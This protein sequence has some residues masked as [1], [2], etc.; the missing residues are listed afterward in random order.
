MSEEKTVVRG[1][2]MKLQPSPKQAETLDEWRH[3]ARK[4]WNLLLG[5]EQAA[6]D[7]RCFR[8]E[9]GWRTIWA[10][11]TASDYLRACHTYKYGKKTK[12]GVVK[13][14]PGDGKEPVEPTQEYY[15]RIA[16]GFIDG[17]P[18]GV[19]IWKSDLN[20]LVARLKDVD[21]TRWISCLPSHAAQ[22]VAAEIETAIKTMLTERRKRAQGAGRNTGFPRFKRNNYAEG[23]V[24]MVNTQ[25][26]FDLDARTVSLPKIKGDMPYRQERIPNGKLMGGRVWR[27]GEQWWMSCQFEIEAPEARPKTGRECGLKISAGVISTTFDGTVVERGP[28]PEDDRKLARRIKLANRRLARR[29]KGTKDYYKT[30]D[31]LATLHAKERDRRDDML[32]KESRRIVNTFDTITVHKMDVSSLMTSEK[33][34]KETGK[35]KKTPRSLLKL[36]KRAAMARFRGFVAYKATDE[37][38]VYNETHK[39]FPEVQ[40]CSACGKLH[41]MPLDKRVMTCDCG[42]VMERRANAA[43]NEFEQGQIVKMATA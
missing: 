8:P 30:A 24:Y 29:N 28:S 38:R 32:H 19:F 3:A 11:I 5:M 37:G 21:G 1:V 26:V 20:K 39:N 15:Q 36:N 27:Q 33:P 43:V 35:P 40:M 42:N 10:D 31:E 25:T 7:G 14:A 12:A 2:K 23:S 41:A 6:Y 16:G 17:K 22:K 34:D 13:K 9:L 4:L 18:P